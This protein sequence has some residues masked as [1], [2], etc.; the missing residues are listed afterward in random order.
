MYRNFGSSSFFYVYHLLARVF[1]RAQILHSLVKMRSWL[2][3]VSHTHT[4]Q[5]HVFQQLVEQPRIDIAHFQWNTKLDRVICTWDL[6]VNSEPLSFTSVYTLRDPEYMKAY[7]KLL[8]CASCLVKTFPSYKK[9]L[10]SAI[11]YQSKTCT[12]CEGHYKTIF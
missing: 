11:L 2:R 7:D 4:N 9:P 1:H 6:P 8:D 5:V 10:A 12:S 3:S